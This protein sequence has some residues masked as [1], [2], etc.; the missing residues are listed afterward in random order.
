MSS[1]ILNTLYLP[2]QANPHAHTILAIISQ[3]LL[4]YCSNPYKHA[5]R[6]RHRR[7]HHGILPIWCITLGGL[8]TGSP[9]PAPRTCSAHG[10]GAA[11]ASGQDHDEDQGPK[12]PCQLPRR[13]MIMHEQPRKLLGTVESAGNC[14]KW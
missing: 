7:G 8:N 9:V 13:I 2:T 3:Q 5:N 6:H 11:A 10:D 12:V 4:L 1:S 14:R